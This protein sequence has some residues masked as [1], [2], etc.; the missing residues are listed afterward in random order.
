M[1]P[2][3]NEANESV[4]RDERFNFNHFLSIPILCHYKEVIN[5]FILYSIQTLAASN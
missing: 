4:I 5:S 1:N 3:S 2:E